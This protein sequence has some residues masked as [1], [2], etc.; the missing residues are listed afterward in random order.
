MQ[1]IDGRLKYKIVYLKAQATSRSSERLVSKYFV[2]FECG[3]RQTVAS[4]G[5]G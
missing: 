4:V 2:F 5:S 3:I 1:G